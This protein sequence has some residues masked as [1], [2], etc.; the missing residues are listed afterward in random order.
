MSL[1]A[2]AHIAEINVFDYFTDIQRHSKLV[3]A[4]PEACFPWNYEANIK[5]LDPEKAAS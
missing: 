2:T 5:S 1:A 3:K 4:N